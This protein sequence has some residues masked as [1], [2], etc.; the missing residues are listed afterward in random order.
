MS[1]A[2]SIV[3]KPDTLR[4]STKLGLLQITLLAA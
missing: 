2:I 1:E 4:D 3:I